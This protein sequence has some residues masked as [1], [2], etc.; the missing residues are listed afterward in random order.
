M[1][2]FHHTTYSRPGHG[3]FSATWWQVGRIILRFR[4]Q[5]LPTTP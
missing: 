5:P 1:L 3:R 2:R 4:E